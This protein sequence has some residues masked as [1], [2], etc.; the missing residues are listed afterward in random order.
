MKKHSLIHCLLLTTLFALTASA[1]AVVPVLSAAEAAGA[2]FVPPTIVPTP[3]P[4]VPL[5]TQAVPTPDCD[6]NLTYIDDLTFPDN[7][8]VEAGSKIDKQWK[9]QNSGTCNWDERYSLR[10]MGGPAMGAQADL[11]LY[12][13]RGGTEATIQIQFTAPDEAGTYRSMWQA[14]GP[15]GEPFGDPIFIQI[16]VQ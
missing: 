14:I 5:P 3:V 16:I 13:A 7:S 11:S 1:C 2:V 4:T 12:P 10:L 9:V 6:D 15:D 8:I